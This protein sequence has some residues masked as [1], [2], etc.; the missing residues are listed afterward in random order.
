MSGSDLVDRL[1]E[2][3]DAA[4]ADVLVL[5]DL[6]LGLLQLVEIVGELVTDDGWQSMHPRTAR[7]ARETLDRT[8]ERLSTH[9]GQSVTGV[10][11]AALRRR[12]A[13]VDRSGVGR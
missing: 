8:V 1:Y 12:F 6:S 9:D 11:V 10:D 5:L 7:S 13:P 2:R 3:L 4:Q